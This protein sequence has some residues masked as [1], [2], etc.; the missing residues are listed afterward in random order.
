[1]IDT[2]SLLSFSVVPRRILANRL[3]VCPVNVVL[4]D[5]VTE[6]FLT[7]PNCLNKEYVAT[8]GLILPHVR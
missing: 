6:K 5:T 8:T 7:R 1:M 3:E 4:K 2:A